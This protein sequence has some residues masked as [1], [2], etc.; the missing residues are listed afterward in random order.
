MHV[1]IHNTKCFVCMN[2]AYFEVSNLKGPAITRGRDST[3]AVVWPSCP[4]GS[5][6]IVGGFIP[7]CTAIL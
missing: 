7:D 3:G 5:T 2:I 1:V 4:A 6:D